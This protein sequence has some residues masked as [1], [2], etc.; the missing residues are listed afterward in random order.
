MKG[1]G[2]L[3]K[4]RTTLCHFFSIL[5]ILTRMEQ[6]RHGGKFEFIN[7]S[8][9]RRIILKEYQT[10]NFKQRLNYSLLRN[11]AS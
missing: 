10:H 2:I 8:I 1:I 11:R 3:S 7:N 4:L 6:K 5:E 9:L